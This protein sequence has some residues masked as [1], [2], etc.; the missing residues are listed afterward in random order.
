MRACVRACMRAC[1]RA[2]MRAC[3]RACVCVCSIYYFSLEFS[4]IAF[5]TDLNEELLGSR[6]LRA[7]QSE[8]QVKI[9]I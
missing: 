1:V 8:L 4:F 6:R 3:M 5:L 2:C 7:E 9:V